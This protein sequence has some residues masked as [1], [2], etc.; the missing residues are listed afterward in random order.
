VQRV[1]EISELYSFAKNNPLEPSVPLY[2]LINKANKIVRVRDTNRSTVHTKRSPT[3]LNCFGYH[4]LI[5]GVVLSYFMELGLDELYSH[6]SYKAVL[7][8]L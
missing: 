4:I 3:L 1:I 5:V 6:Y 8:L 7:F 2:E